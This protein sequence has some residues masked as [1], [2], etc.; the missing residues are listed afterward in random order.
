MAE[1]ALGTKPYLEDKKYSKREVES[2][3]FYIVN[4]I[5]EVIESTG[6]GITVESHHNAI[7]KS[8]VISVNHENKSYRMEVL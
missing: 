7:N 4:N 2:L 1:L 5:N 8:I 3:I 6:S